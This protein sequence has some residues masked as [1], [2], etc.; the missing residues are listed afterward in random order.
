MFERSK[1]FTLVEL[2]VVLAIIAV[3]IALLLPAVQY[4]REAARRRSC[5]NNLKQIGTAI[6][7]HEATHTFFPTG[8]WG[9]DWVGDPD[10]GFAEK[11][12]GGWHF[13]IL[14]YL[15]ESNLREIGSR[16]DSATKRS[17]RTELLQSPIAVF[18]CP[19]RRADKLY[20]YTGP[21][22]LRN[23]D[24]PPSVAKSDYAVNSEISPPRQVVSEGDLSDSLSKTALAGEKSLHSNHYEDGT[25][26]GDRLTMYVGDC[27]D[28]RRSTG[29]PLTFDDSA[30]GG[31][32]SAHSSGCNLVYGDGS[33][34]F[35]SYDSTID[36]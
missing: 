9:G 1:G 23:A 6:L 34:R 36:Q 33:V 3:L 22:P 26:D 29:S 31:F 32:G 20:P 17:T 19:S 14:P 7:H 16:T 25:D 2:L 15:E 8:G 11:Q 21:V 12:P 5:A 24:P 28:V 4:S 10:A 35:V 18:Y 13:N 27:T 30:G